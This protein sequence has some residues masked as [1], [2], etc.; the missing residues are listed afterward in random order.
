MKDI[1]LLVLST[2]FV[3]FSATLW[4]LYLVPIQAKAP[5]RH[6]LFRRTHGPLDAACKA[7]FCGTPSGTGLCSHQVT[8]LIGEIEVAVGLVC[9]HF[10]NHMAAEGYETI[11]FYRPYH[12]MR[13]P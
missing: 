6:V 8:I 5:A 11:A 1:T 12:F 13:L 2:L 10:V 4:R 9:Q 7:I 3:E